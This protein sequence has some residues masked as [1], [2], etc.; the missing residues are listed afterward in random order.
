MLLNRKPGD[1]R[2]GRYTLGDEVA[3]LPCSASADSLLFIGAKGLL[4]TGG[5]KGFSVLI[6]GS[7]GILMAQARYSVSI[8]FVDAGT[9][10]V[11]AFTRISFL[12]G[13]AGHDPRTV[14]TGRFIQEFVNISAPSRG[15]R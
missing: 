4:Q 12:G 14:L 9:G 5:R 10:D 8:A 1:V 13:K 11:T 7:A 3:E 15:R 6:G 2:K